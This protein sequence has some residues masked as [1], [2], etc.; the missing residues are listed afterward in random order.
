MPPPRAK[1]TPS[2]RLRLIGGLSVKHSIRLMILNGPGCETGPVDGELN[3]AT[4]EALRKFQA[5]A[6]LKP[7]VEVTRPTA[8]ELWNRWTGER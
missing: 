6:G 4:L 3:E 5:D 1:P 2:I 7:T 8:I